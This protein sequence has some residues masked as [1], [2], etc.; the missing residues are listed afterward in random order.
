MSREIHLE[1][2]SLNKWAVFVHMNNYNIVISNAHQKINS[3]NFIK[4]HL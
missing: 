4:I 3:C 1:Y 2:L